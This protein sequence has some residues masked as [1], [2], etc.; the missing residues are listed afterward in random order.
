MKKPVEVPDFLQD[1][2]G[3]VYT[4]ISWSSLRKLDDPDSA[5]ILNPRRFYEEL[6]QQRYVE[7][8][9]YTFTYVPDVLFRRLV[10]CRKPTQPLE[11]VGMGLVRTEIRL[12]PQL[13]TKL[14]ICESRGRHPFTAYIGSQNLVKPTTYNIMLR[15]K[16]ES[17]I[18]A[19]RRYYAMIWTEAKPCKI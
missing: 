6:A 11:V 15:I 2:L 5:L 1:D 12:H 10:L 8:L 16:D 13:H 14:F 9:T 18:S 17:A 4:G 19:L 7:A 3:D